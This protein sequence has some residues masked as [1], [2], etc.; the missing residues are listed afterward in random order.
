MRIFISYSRSDSAF[1]DRLQADLLARNFDA[2]VDRQKLEGGQ[3][4]EKEIQAGLDRSSIVIVVL[5]PHAAASPWV[6]TE[7]TYA[8][9]KQKRIIPLLLRGDDDTVPFALS[10]I[11]YI[12]VRPGYDQ[13][14]EQLLIALTALSLSTASSAEVPEDAGV[15][16]LPQERDLD[17]LY[18]EGRK[19]QAAGELDRAYIVW[20][21]VLDTQPNYG[22]GSLAQ[23][24]QD[25]ERQLRPIRIRRL[26]EQVS[27]ARN[28][29]ETGQLIGALQALIAFDPNDTAAN[30]ELC[31]LLDA[32]AEEAR[33]EGRWDDEIAARQAL[34]RLNPKD[35]QIAA[36]QALLRQNPEDKQTANE[37]TI[38]EQ[39]KKWAWRYTNVR[40]FVAEGELPA[41]RAEL[42]RLWRDAP[43]YGDPNGLA[44]KIGLAVGETYRA[45]I[46]R[47]EVEWA[48]EARKRNLEGVR[49]RAAIALLT[50][51]GVVLS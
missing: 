11:Q 4:W 29:G 27:A 47:E 7:Y 6:E 42:E 33:A 5:S 24:M 16:R 18:R 20:K 44:P 30:T 28:A 43:F 40:Q 50:I 10:R 25:V 21:Q 9:R 45:K 31:R 19:A 26:R 17:E 1:V 35:E 34:L 3:T 32:R 8:L 14:F 51:P 48:E 12:D 39:N 2:W 49:W 36:P 38:A 46:A 13:G 23:D 41:A 15:V 22:A 37:I